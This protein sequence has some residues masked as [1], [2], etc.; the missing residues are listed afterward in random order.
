[1]GPSAGP[2]GGKAA[3]GKR[4]TAAALAHLSA[5]APAARPAPLCVLRKRRLLHRAPEEG[6]AEGAGGAATDSGKGTAGGGG[7]R[8]MR[9]EGR[10][11]SRGRIEVR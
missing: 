11:S 9:G 3:P 10:G 1:M 4:G 8:R 6:P 2:R 7:R 5:T